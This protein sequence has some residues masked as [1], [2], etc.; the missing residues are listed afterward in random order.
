M[1]RWV[2]FYEQK[3]IP[4]TYSIR[5]MFRSYAIDLYDDT[6]SVRPAGI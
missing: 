4:R 5:E 1:N 2:N 3:D 6:P